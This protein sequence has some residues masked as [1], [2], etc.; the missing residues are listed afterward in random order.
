MFTRGQSPKNPLEEEPTSAKE[1]LEPAQRRTF[2][3]L[4]ILG[5]TGKK[6]E[7][8]LSGKREAGSFLLD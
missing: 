8:P 3:C 6:T 5:F 7:R 1:A 4:M 2:P